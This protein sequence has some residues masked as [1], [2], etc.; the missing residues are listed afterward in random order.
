[1]NLA[2]WIVLG[3]VIIAIGFAIKATFFK[4]K[5][6]G[7]CCDTGDKPLGSKAGSNAFGCSPSACST[8]SCSSCSEM[9]A[10]YKPIEKDSGAA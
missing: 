3:I 6:K 5:R 1:V 8:C 4:K 7:G 2:S 10:R 9:A